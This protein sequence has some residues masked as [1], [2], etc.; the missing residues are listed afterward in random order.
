M[1]IDRLSDNFF[2]LSYVKSIFNFLPPPTNVSPENWWFLSDHFF[3]LD[4][5]IFFVFAG[6]I[7]RSTW[8]ISPYFRHSDISPIRK[9]PYPSFP[10]LDFSPATS[11][12]ENAKSYRC[13]GQKDFLP[14]GVTPAVFP[15]KNRCRIVWHRPTQSVFGVALSRRGLPRRFSA[16]IIYYF[17]HRRFGKQKRVIGFNFD[18]PFDPEFWRWSGWESE[19]FANNYNCDHTRLPQVHAT[20]VIS[21]VFKLLST[22]NFSD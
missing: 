17:R 14:S 19:C 5:V 21:G 20:Y 11:A 2:Q 12:E 22:I 3:S 9:R 13:A 6:F 18:W 10:F 16:T 1:K 8:K 7:W 4:C 15:N